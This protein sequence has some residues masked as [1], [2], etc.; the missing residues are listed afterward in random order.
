GNRPGFLKTGGA[1]RSFPVEEFLPGD[2]DE[3]LQIRLVCS[4]P[5]RN[6]FRQCGPRAGANADAEVSHAGD[7]GLPDDDAGG[8]LRGERDGLALLAFDALDAVGQ[9]QAETLARGGIVDVGRDG[10]ELA[11][12][13][14]AAEGEGDVS[15]SAGR[16]GDAAAIGVSQLALAAG[17]DL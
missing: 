6:Q 2:G 12:L 15:F 9:F 8:F 14:G 3:P 10:E 4:A 1:E 17:L 7:A 13:E 5:D 16:G 11:R